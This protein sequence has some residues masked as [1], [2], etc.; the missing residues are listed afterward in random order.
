MKRLSIPKLMFATL[1]FIMMT[2]CA[3]RTV[4]VPKG[5]HHNQHEKAHV[6]YKVKQ[7]KRHCWRH[8]GHWD[9]RKG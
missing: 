7:A 8:R 6:V 9:C 1:V 5:H 4:V 3:T 2:G